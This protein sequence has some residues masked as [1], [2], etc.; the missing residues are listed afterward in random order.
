MIDLKTNELEYAITI[1]NSDSSFKMDAL[2]LIHGIIL[3]ESEKIKDLIEVKGRSMINNAILSQS[4][5]NIQQ[6]LD[7]ILTEEDQTKL[8]NC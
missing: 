3:S 6:I 1:A 8:I 5:E 2:R 4:S 7:E